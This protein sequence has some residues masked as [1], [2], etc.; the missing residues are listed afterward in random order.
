MQRMLS[1]VLLLCSMTLL[2]TDI[3]FSEGLL[4][5]AES[6]DAE[7]QYGLGMAYYEGNG[8]KQNY[9]EAARWYRKAADQG[10]AEAQYRLGCMYEEGKG[11][12]K[13]F[14]EALHWLR[15]AADQEHISAQS[16]LGSLYLWGSPDVKTGISEGVKWYLKAAERET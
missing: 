13:D 8:I 12:K 1:L 6:G 11:L 2:A 9:F 10:Y 3:T 5:Q 4:Q 15:M 14:S 7:A 16:S